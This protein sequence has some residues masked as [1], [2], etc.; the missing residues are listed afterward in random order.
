MRY[1]VAMIFGFIGLIV[2][3][4]SQGAI[5]VSIAPVSGST[6]TSVVG[7]S[8]NGTVTGSYSTTANFSDEHGFVRTSNGKFTTFDYGTGGTEPRGINDPGAIVGI[9]QSVGCSLNTSPSLAACEEFERSKSGKFTT[10]KKGGTPLVGISQGIN[11]SGQF[12]GSY[13]TGSA[14][15]PVIAGFYGANGVYLSDLTLPFTTQTTEPRGVNA[16]GEVVGFFLLPGGNPQGF[17]LNGGVVT[18]FNYPDPA[19]T[20]TIPEGINDKGQISGSRIDGS[21]NSHGFLVSADLSTFTSIDIP[22]APYTQGWGLNN[23]A[24]VIVESDVASF[25]YCSN[26]SDAHKYCKV[27]N[28]SSTQATEQTVRVPAD[29]HRQYQCAANCLLATAPTVNWLG[30]QQAPKRVPNAKAPQHLP[31]MTP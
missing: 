19:Q 22:G 23:A 15:N 1:I 3:S 20:G 27:K 11:A 26:N 6:S 7:I 13:F 18:V 4:A 8:N 12:V 28:G 2:A 16:S 21:G 10:I 17:L 25:I 29:S 24:E 5:L 31:R 9:F 30:L 14:T